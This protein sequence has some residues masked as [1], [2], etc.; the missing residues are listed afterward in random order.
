MSGSVRGSSEPETCH[1]VLRRRRRASRLRRDRSA[2]H[3]RGGVQPP[4]GA[5]DPRRPGGRQHRRLRVLQPAEP[6]QRHLRRQL[7]C[8]SRSRT[9]GPNFYPWADDAEYL[10][11]ID[12]NGDAVADVIYRWR[13]RTEDQ[14]G[15]RH[16]PLQQRAGHLA[17]GREP[18]LPPV[19]H[20]RREHRRRRALRQADR[21]GQAAPSYTGAGE[22]G[23]GAG[24]RRRTCATRRSADVAGGGRT[25]TT[26][27]EDPFFLDLRIF[28]LLY[29]G[30]LSER[31]QD[32]LAGYNVNSIVLE[33]PKAEVAA[34]QG[35]HGEPGHRRLEHDDAADA[36]QRR[37]HRGLAAAT[38]RCPASASRWSTRSSSR[39]G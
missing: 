16:V 10:I 29:G 38:P 2:A 5:A 21:Q 13:F 36:A 18:A 1:R 4:R 32:T 7:D 28:D 26:Q 37:R 25:L 39:P 17:R 31:G 27:T 35:R 23:L 19:L 22:H 3:R 34:R 33:V 11:N 15:A 9:A 24:L 12:N 20:P 6:E 14:R 30:D 8:P